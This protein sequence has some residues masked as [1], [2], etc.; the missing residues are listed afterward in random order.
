MSEKKVASKIGLLS[1]IFLF[2]IRAYF[3]IISGSLALLS[4]AVNSFTDILASVGIY[5]AVKEGEKRKDFDHPYGHHAAEPIS[6][7]L[8]SVLAA[9]LAF[10]IFRSAIEGLFFPRELNVTTIT[11]GV[12]I[13]SIFIKLGLYFYFKNIGKEKGQVINAY[14]VDSMNDVFTS[15]IVLLGVCGAYLGYA[16]LDD[17]AAIVVSLY[18]FKAAFDLGKTNINFL[19]GGSPDLETLKKIKERAL[20]HREVKE[21]EVNAHYFGDTLHVELILRVNKRFAISKAHD[22]GEIVKKDLQ[23]TD[24]ISHVYVHMEPA[25]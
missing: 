22:I 24:G 6:A 5:L 9:I 4:D 18:I 14:M 10:E 20:R 23:K 12:V 8:V 16:M 17:I 13:L 25:D 7:F 3:G 15:S 11:V 2:I 21:A 1:N 19:M